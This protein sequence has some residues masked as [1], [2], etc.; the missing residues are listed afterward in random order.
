MASTSSGSKSR[1]PDKY[2]KCHASQKVKTVVCIICENVYHSS[3][4]VRLEKAIQLSAVLGI[5]PEHEGLDLTS[6]V[7]RK[8]LT[9]EARL[10][11][12][13]VKSMDRLEVRKQILEEFEININEDGQEISDDN[14]KR[15]NALLR[16][17][18]KELKEKNELLKQLL[19]KQRVEMPMVKTKTYAD[20]V[21][22]NTV[23]K[24]P[25]R[26]P[27]IIIKRTEEDET[28]DNL[29]QIVSHYLIKDKTIQTKKIVTKSDEIIINC[30]NEESVGKAHKILKSKLADL[31]DVSKEQVEN[32]KVKVVGI[33]NFENMDD[34]SIENDIN[35]RNFSNLKKKC[36]VLNSYKNS[37]TKL[38]T[39][40]LD[41][42]AEIYQ[43]IR[44]NKN[45]L[46]VGYQN[47]KVFDYCSIKPCFNCGR[48]GHN[49]NKCKNSSICLKCA[50]DHK[51]F[52]CQVTKMRCTNCDF[53]NSRYKTN[54]DIEHMAT[55]SQECEIL[56][57]KIR[58]YI[59]FTDY[60]IKPTL[61]RYIGTVMKK[62]DRGNASRSSS[63]TAQ[64]SNPNMPERLRRKK[65]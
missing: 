64:S 44:E 25:K 19:D 10:V 24:K 30:L 36:S 35:E 55:D 11:I 23:V 31:C 58:K 1:L 29:N 52:E 51:T 38:Q 59:D 32:P 33:N 49:S 8:L 39:V 41:M 63:T 15:E 47:C 28:I 61:P 65:N 50:G 54:F 6:K 46:F 37:E 13:Q 53:S 18:N 2:Y 45:R 16:E 57:S 43:H 21:S 42:P 4:F 48:F 20:A 60:T 56:Q 26:V 7:N 3:D 22:Y 5:C 14:L 40:I 9:N 34:K 27:S 12:S 17:L 62:S